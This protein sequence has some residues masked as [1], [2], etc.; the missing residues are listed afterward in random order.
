MFLNKGDKRATTPKV[1]TWIGKTK[2][3]KEQY[4]DNWQ[5]VS[6]DHKIDDSIASK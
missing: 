5:I 3:L 2:V 6:K 4:W 1:W